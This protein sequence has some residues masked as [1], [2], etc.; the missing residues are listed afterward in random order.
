MKK[1]TKKKVLTLTLVILLLSIAIVGGSLAWFTA[2][3]QVDNVF[4][5]GSIKIKQNEYDL[6]D[7]EKVPYENKDKVFMPI[8]NTGDPSADPN[9][10]DK[11]VTVSNTGNNAA[12]VRTHIAVPTA[13]LGYLHL[14]VDLD[15]PWES[16]G[17]YTIT[18]T[19]NVEYTV[20]YYRYDT[21]L[22]KGKE[23][24][25]LLKGVYMDY[26]VDV[27]EN[28][29]PNTETGDTQFCIRNDD[30][31]Y[32][33]SDFMVKEGT[34]IK[35]LVATQAVQADGFNGNVG[36]ALYNAFGTPTATSNPFVN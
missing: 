30:G 6:E 31:T 2:E 10:H 12:Y 18:Y 32:S 9:Y 25:D 15:N 27:K 35:V 8:V 19:D 26:A 28:P 14:E 23:T 3:D 22:E 29:D 11:I 21:I 1:N 24:L 13:L 5:V 20:F 7:G 17:Q 16:E 36:N 4:T 33:Y 34:Q